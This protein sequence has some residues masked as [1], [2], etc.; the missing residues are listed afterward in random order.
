MTR[1]HKLIRY[2]WY[3]LYY[4]LAPPYR[5]VLVEE[6]LPERLKRRTL[7]VVQE[8]GF[9]EQA[10]MLCPCR[11][12]RVLHMNLLSDERPCWYLTQNSDGT[13]N[14]YPSVRSIKDCGTHF[15]FQRGRVQWC[16]SEN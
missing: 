5:T 7:Y 11:C 2:I 16:R 1:I 15:W 12:R 8:S 14:L 3:R 9:E 10:A 4:W 6:A 13:A